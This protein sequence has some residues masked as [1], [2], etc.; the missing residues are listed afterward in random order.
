MGISRSESVYQ[1]NL[2]K[3]IEHLLPDCF[4]FKMDPD[5]YQGV[6][7][8]LILFEG[9]W[10]AL[11]VKVASSS[12]VQPNQEWYIEKFSD[13]SFASFIYPSNEDEVLEEMVS[14]LA[15]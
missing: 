1:A 10:A 5:Q 13:M 8:L 14:R 3:R 7:D 9:N 15:A 4:V 12:E 11:E 6:P 2:I